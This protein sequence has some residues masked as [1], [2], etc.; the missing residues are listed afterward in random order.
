MRRA[1]I[2]HRRMMTV[3]SG[4]VVEYGQPITETLPNVTATTAELRCQVGKGEARLAELE[5][6]Y[7]SRKSPARATRSQP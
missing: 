2:A 3:V 5:R 1:A 6:R 7:A 4:L